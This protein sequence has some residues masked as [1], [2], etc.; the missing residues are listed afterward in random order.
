MNQ[1]EDL[2]VGLIVGAMLSAAAEQLG[3]VL[4]VASQILAGEGF[5]NAEIAAVADRMQALIDK[6]VLASKEIERMRGAAE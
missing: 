1:K 4:A 5:S 3:G 2:A 6:S